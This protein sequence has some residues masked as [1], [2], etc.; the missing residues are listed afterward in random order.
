MILK[1]KSY[2]KEIQTALSSEE[3]ALGTQFCFSQATLPSEEFAL[4]TQFRFP[5]ET[6]S[7]VAQRKNAIY[8]EQ[9]LSQK[10]RV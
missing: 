6:V 4:G 1:G 3:F 2:G 8:H 5:I 10:E 9:Q 7:E